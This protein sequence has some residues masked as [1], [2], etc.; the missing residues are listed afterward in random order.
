M[1]RKDNGEQSP[2]C[3]KQGTPLHGSVKRPVAQ[4]DVDFDEISSAK[5]QLQLPTM[6]PV[7]S[8]GGSDGNVMDNVDAGA[9]AAPA[10]MQFRFSDIVAKKQDGK[11]WTSDEIEWFVS[12]MV[13][14][15]GTIEDAQIGKS[16]FRLII[17]ERKLCILDM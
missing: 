5:R 10:P 3:A 8:P 7:K 4:A 16:K 11:E 13:S 9:A 1:G 2:T 14:G 6:P 15:K 12:E 17:F